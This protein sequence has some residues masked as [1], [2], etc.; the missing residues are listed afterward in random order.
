MFSYY[1]VYQ[2]MYLWKSRS[3]L[4]TDSCGGTVLW[5]LSLQKYLFSPYF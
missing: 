4:Q 5:G 2:L 3:S 1:G